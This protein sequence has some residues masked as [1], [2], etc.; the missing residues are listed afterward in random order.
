VADLKTMPR[1]G[2]AAAEGLWKV[3]ERTLLSNRVFGEHYVDDLTDELR[4]PVLSRL[5]MYVSCKCSKVPIII[6][7]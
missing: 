6:K 1:M 7:K 4:R 3:H 5:R 2:P